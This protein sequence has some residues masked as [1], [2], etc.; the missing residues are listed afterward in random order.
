MKR[1]STTFLQVIFVLIGISTLALL[2]WEP[3]LEGANVGKSTFD[4]YFK[5]PFLA[6]VYLA[7]IAWFAII[8]Q[9]IRSLQQVKQN[10]TFSAA[11]VKAL[12]TIKFCG[13]FLIGCI[14]LVEAYIHIVVRR[15]GDDI[16]GGSAIGLMLIFL[17]TIITVAASMFQKVVQHGAELK[18][19]NDLTV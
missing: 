3:R 5:D 1:S 19:E 2:L 13:L 18:S 6:F 11:N 10:T 17:L 7:S 4:I 9:A 8:Y 15:T 12:R 16:A 14:V